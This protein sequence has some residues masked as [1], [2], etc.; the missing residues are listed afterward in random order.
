M[1]LFRHTP[2]ELQTA[3]YAPQ[4]CEGFP[5][6]LCTFNRA[7]V[8]LKPSQCHSLLSHPRTF[9]PMTI[10]TSKDYFMHTLATSQARGSLR[11]YIF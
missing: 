3:R 2:K 6:T 11:K 10:H 8:A 7:S 4:A 9:N 5:V 1:L